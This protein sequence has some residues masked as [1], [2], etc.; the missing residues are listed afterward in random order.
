MIYIAEIRRKD[1]ILW[2]YLREFD[3]VGLVEI[4]EVGENKETTPERIAW[5]CLKEENEKKK[6]R[7]E[8]GII[9]RVGHDY[10]EMSKT[11]NQNGKDAAVKKK[12]ITERKVII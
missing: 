9:T 11:S 5:E 8:G 7:A 12:R 6:V 2:E 10:Q 1:K 3:V 4:S